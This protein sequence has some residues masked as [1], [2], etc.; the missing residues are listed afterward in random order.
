MLTLLLGTDWKHNRQV[1]LHKIAAEV[2]SEKGGIIW[3]VP[4]LVSHQTERELALSAG[5]TASRLAEVLSFSRLAKR[6]SE[7]CGIAL[8]ECL[9][10]GGRVVAMAAATRQLHSK[11][12]AYAAVETKPEFLTGLLDAVD[13]FKRCC[14]TPADL[15]QASRQTEGNLAQK[16]EELSLILES[17]NAI[18]SRGKRDPRDQMTWL[19]EQLEDCEFAK[20][21]IFFFD[22][23]PD[24]SRQHMEILYH[25]LEHS[26]QVVISLNCDRP[27]SDNMAF[28]KAGQTAADIIGYVT[29]NDIP[30]E[31][32]TLQGENSA[33][34]QVSQSLLQGSIREGFA[35]QCLHMYSAE[36][37][38][39]ECAATVEKIIDHIQSGCRY[40]DISIVCPD[41]QTYQGPVN[42]LL[43]RAHIPL[44][45][46]GTEDILEKTVIHTVLCAMDAA[47]SGFACKD[48]IRYL[49]SMLSPVE[50]DL[51]DKIENYAIMWSIDGN[52]WL[53]EW[54][55]H[56][57]G[58]EDQWT[59]RD[60]AILSSLN[61]ARQKALMP[62][63]CLRDSFRDAI[64]VPQQV[65]ALYQFLT[66][67]QLDSRLRRLAGQ[68]EE[69]GDYRNAQI[70][71]QLWEILLGALE[72]L[73]DTLTEISWD[74]E[75]FSRLLRLL[76]RQY[77]VGT[78]PS[79]LDSVTVG[80][81][82]SM[83][84]QKARHLF[85]LGMSEGAFPSYGGSAGVLND[86]ERSVLLSLGVPL[87]P[88]A[89]DGLQTQFSEIQEVFSGATE[90]ISVFC[91][92]GQPSFVYN[93][94][95]R[96]AGHE[97]KILPNY[98]AALTDS[99]EAAAYLAVHNGAV[100]A[101]Q[102]GVEQEFRKIMEAKQ[103]QLGAIHSDNVRLLYGEKLNLSASQIDRV[104][105][106]RLSY[107]LKY[108]MRA[109]ERNPASIDPAEFGTYVHAVLE[110]CGRA[111]VDKGGFKNVSLEHTLELA[112]DS[113]ARYFANRFSQI[114]TERINYHFEKN[115]R[116]VQLIVEELWK[117]MQESAFEA[118]DF[119]LGFGADDGKMPAIS[120]PGRKMDAQLRG[121]VDRVDRWNF[122]GKDYIRVVDYK[123][124]KKDFDYCDVFN[125]IG[126]QMLLYLYALEDGGEQL[127]GDT[128]IVAG[129]QYFPARVPLVTSDGSMSAEEA[130][131]A[132]LKDFKR[133]GL[134]LSDENVLRA[135]E[136]SDNPKRLSVKRKKDGSFTG[137]IAT[138]HQFAQLKRYV[139]HLLEQIV[140]EIASGN[141][142][143]NPY[144][145]GA[146]HDA[147]RFCPYG[148]VCRSAEV[149]GRRNYQ[150]MTA[151]RFWTEIERSEQKN[152]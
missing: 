84:C 63:V 148:A 49:K 32:Q 96:M 90:S 132:H 115:S 102:L 34:Q 75:T 116:E 135:M 11:L 149:E 20:N 37:V 30:Y 107:F 22:C 79:V 98:G 87:N 121:Y 77:D 66:D 133:K 122:A 54:K 46:S 108:G 26:P 152:G 86:Q 67:I 137:D 93:R 141:V 25:L 24:F 21:H 105:E 92:D 40:R 9:D 70:L 4:E 6:V 113:S 118:Y 126:L 117:E 61:E 103:H 18:C 95:K 80:S 50:P 65:V 94:L 16:L 129:V 147:C 10:N 78:I 58:L 114:S 89:I 101:A 139:F 138:S 23:F 119:E 112:A 125:G 36:S 59:D 33:L 27:G 19:L 44:Y 64:S 3:M 68:M 104:A 99:W 134:I 29:R 81:V 17:Y 73:H 69:N 88:G 71:N 100:E 60:M 136:P 150:A 41:M 42:A 7:D 127:F 47:L 8:A 43:Q 31:L 111:I 28:D 76:L 57:R 53:Q 97:Q 146:S 51:C 62:L 120:I 45:L 151:D 52:R 5:D 2:K 91:S 72:Q 56:P 124:G 109:K 140:D 143:P 74:G 144:T 38:Y 106:C 12:K 39:G 13:E 145:R 83:R 142:T 15:M 82:S 14:I 128:P 1:I 123:T 110:E 55:N 35:D 131:Q 85:V 130:E 48:V